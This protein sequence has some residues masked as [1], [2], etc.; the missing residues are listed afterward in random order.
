MTFHTVI[1]YETI[2]LWLD[3]VRHLV[4]GADN[5]AVAF[6]EVCC[7]PSSKLVQKFVRGQ[8]HWLG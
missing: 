5:L 7:T 8:G 1:F 3:R 2:S 6:I 4:F